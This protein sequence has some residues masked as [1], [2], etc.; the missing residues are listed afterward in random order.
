MGF[1]Q[2][3]RQLGRRRALAYVA[4]WMLRIFAQRRER[5]DDFIHT[6]LERGYGE[7]LLEKRKRGRVLA[8]GLIVFDASPLC[9][10]R[11]LC[12]V[13]TRDGD[14]PKQSQARG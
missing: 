9:I 5:L 6:W 3:A 4:T 13:E 10:H 2:R 14:S 7:R 11:D 12:P 1:S 8:H